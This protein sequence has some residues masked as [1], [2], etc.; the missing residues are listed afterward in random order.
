MYEQSNIQSLIGK[1]ITQLFV[2]PEYFL[3]I[4]D[5]NVG[6]LVDLYADCCS[7][8]FFYDFYGVKN[9]LENGPITEVKSVPLEVTDA[10]KSDGGWGMKDKTSEDIDIKAYGYQLTTIHPEFGEVTS[11]F[12]FRNYSNGYYGGEIHSVTMHADESLEEWKKK[13]TELTN[14][15]NHINILTDKPE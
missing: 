7:S 10:V 4:S 13:L 1:R 11:V 12:S 2:S 3:F 8:S 5:K 15:T 6:Y 9:L 14:D